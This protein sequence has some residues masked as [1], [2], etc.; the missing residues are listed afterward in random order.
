MSALLADVIITE[1]EKM[2]VLSLFDG[3]SCGQI[4]LRELGIKIDKYYAS[5]IDK[6][7]I[8]NTMVNFPDT[9]QSGGQERHLLWA[10][11]LAAGPRPH[12]A[13]VG[14]VDLPCRYDVARIAAVYSAQIL[15]IP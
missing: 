9:M 6:F 1:G 13:A 7:A 2:I 11:L 5:E 15:E 3:M 8:H 14:D 12:G 4:A 10:V